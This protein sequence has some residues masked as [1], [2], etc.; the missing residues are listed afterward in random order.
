MVKWN[1]F[2]WCVRPAE[3]LESDVFVDG[4][5]SDVEEDEDFYPDDCQWEQ[6]EEPAK[7]ETTP[8]ITEKVTTLLLLDTAKTFL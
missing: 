8:V 7:P 2:V 4:D 6:E 3:A 5:I 1:V